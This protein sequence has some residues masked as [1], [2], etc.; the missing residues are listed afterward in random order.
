MVYHNLKALIKGIRACKTVADERALIKQESAAIRASFREEDSYAR[1][2]NVAKLLYIHMLGS[3]AHFGQMEC[4]KLVASP[5]FG[6][7]RL[8]YLGIMLL[9]DEKQEVLTLVTN[10][11]KN[12]MNHANMYAVG[13]ALCTFADIASEEMSRDLAN[14][15]EK[16]LGS[17][18]TYIRKKAALCALRVVRKVPELADHFVTK[19]K[20]L[21]ADRNHGVLLTAITLV[22]EMC[23]IDPNCLEEFRNA[24]PM[25]VRH[26]KA[27]VTTGYSPEHDVSGITD[28]FLQTKILRLMRF[29]G[30]NDPKASETMNDILAQVATNTDSTKNV[31]N[32][33]LYETVMTV[34][35][36][37][38]DSGLRVMAINIL[39]KFLSNRD[40]NIRYVALNTL[41]KVV[42]IDTNAVQRHRNIILDCLRDGDISIRRRALELSYALINEQNVRI[43]IRE[44]LAFLEVADDEFKLGMTTQICLAAERFAPNKRWHID[45]VLRVLKLAGNFVRE[46]I[47]SGFIRLVAHTPELQAYTTSKL[48]TSLHSDI[49]QESLTLAATWLVGEYSEIILEGGLVDEETPK[50]ITDHEL[51]DLLISTLDSPYANYL[52]RQFVL[53]AL[54]KMSS[55]PTTGAMQQERIQNLLLSYTTSLELEIQQRAVE[56]ASLFNLSQVREGVLERMPP[57]E[58]KQT[59][60]GYG[61]EKKPVGSVQS[62]QDATMIDL[63]GEDTTPAANGAP[64]VANSTQDLLAS[65]FGG[66]DAS[67]APAA[68][69]SPAPPAPPTQRDIAKDILGLFDS[70]NPSGSPAPAAAASPPPPAG[71]SAMAGMGGMGS[72]FAAAAATPAAPSPVP[73]APAGYIAYDQ[74]ELKVTLVPQTSPTRPGL[75]RVVASF[76]ATG[77]APISGLNFQAAVTKTQQLQMAPISSAEVVPGKMETQE[78]RVLAPVGAAIRLRLRIAF[79]VGGRTVQDTVDFN[80]FPPGLTGGT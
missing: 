72:V 32:S 25:L 47:L 26:L 48:Y 39:G 11:L 2:N 46:E 52:T 28:P 14:E 79:T 65:L 12:D 20:N 15:I 37:E 63:L 34:L 3:E 17:S 51:I 8:G 64:A 55:R 36:I 21:L 77:M 40:N 50:S 69:G 42:A 31:G 80:S 53:T 7:K 56:F 27:L 75:V 58:V 23:E 68:A 1:H 10:S 66:A 60:Y 54:T 30:R 4:L 74:N 44:L 71:M 76:L 70:P 49:S 5:R 18:N 16:L 73:V 57:P 19:A 59:V 29:L 6:D 38:A 33:I 45:T 35:E 24:V 9:L 13:L 67:P 62:G 22:T 61:S 78:M 41:N 43:L